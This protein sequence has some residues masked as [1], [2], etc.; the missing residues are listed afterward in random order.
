MISA[1]PF[2][3]KIYIPATVF[4]YV[5]AGEGSSR[6][7]ILDIAGS[8]AR[9]RLIIVSVGVV[10]CFFI[11]LLRLINLSLNEQTILK[12]S[13]SIVPISR[14]EITDRNGIILAT[15]LQTASLYADTTKTIDIHEA[16]VKLSRAFPDVQFTEIKAKLQAGLESRSHFVWI[17][18]NLIPSQQKMVY[19]LGIPGLFFQYETRRVY[20][21]GRL[22]SHILGFSDVDSK[23][24]SGVEKYFDKSLMPTG[25]NQKLTLSIDLSVQH[26]VSYELAAAIDKFKAIGG[27]AIVQNV[28]NGEIIAMVSLP[29]FDPN[30]PTNSPS[31]NRYNGASSG[32]Y[33]MGSVMKI[34]NTAMVLDDGSATLNSIY[35]TSQPIHIARFTIND[36]HAENRTL[37]LPEVFLF[38]SNIGSAR[39]VMEA[40]KE[41]Q[42]AFFEKIGMLKRVNIELPETAMP[43]LPKP[44]S[45]I[46]AMTI[47]FGHGIGVTPLHVISGLSAMVNGGILFTPTL[48]QGKPQ[49]GVRVISPST[50]EKMRQL[51][52]L[53]VTD[54]TG[55]NAEVP[56]YMVGGKTGTSE[57]ISKTGGYNKTLLLNSFAAAF[58][59]DK[60]RYA[61][62]VVLNEPQALPETYG[63]ATAGWNA[64]PT[65]AKII[66]RIAL[67]LGIEPNISSMQSIQFKQMG[68]DNGD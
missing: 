35:D 8:R 62:L 41:K 39:M 13:G 58:P 17:K 2:H 60:P 44:W 15:S 25:S 33:E 40:G 50:S 68:N 6:Q 65:M 54:G 61:V 67:L 10:L 12:R 18:R 36:Y 31:A 16:A 26:A 59:I 42:K 51:L 52:R 7:N 34:F 1:K 66:S 47:S 55:K 19:E 3:P 32:V 9:L 27:Q 5:K 23:G 53:A 30:F 14:A 28:Q 20:P 57:K 21:N 29:D 56:G 63:F 64:A 11:L 37:T 46:S 4:L 22:A 38:S 49:N 48:L 43:L 24:I 45:D